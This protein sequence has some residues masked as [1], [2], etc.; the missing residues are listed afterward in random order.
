ME[1][2]KYDLSHNIEVFEIKNVKMKTI[3]VWFMYYMPLDKSASLNALISR[4]I[5]KGSSKYRNTGEIAR[6]LYENYGSEIGVDIGLKGE[7]YTFSMYTRF[8]N[9]K[10]IPIDKSLTSSVLG[11]FNDILFNSLIIDENFQDNY[12]ELEKQ[13][14]INVIENRVN[15][16]DTYALE[17]CIEIMCKNEPYGI[18]R[19]GRKEWA[20]NINSGEVVRRYNEIT[21]S[22]PLKIYV[23]GNLEWCGALGYI[24]SFFKLKGGR[25]IEFINKSVE[26]NEVTYQTDEMDISQSR[27]CMGFRTGINLNSIEYPALIVL[28]NILGG[29]PQSKLF[30]EIREKE[31]LCYSIYSLL[32]KYK[33]LM[34]VSCGIDYDK[35]DV[36]IN[37]IKELIYK[38]KSGEFTDEEFYNALSAAKKDIQM[39][40]DNTFN[41]LSYIQGLNIYK[42]DYSVIDLI[43]K[44][45][46]VTRNDVINC[47]KKIELD[48]IYL[49]GS[50]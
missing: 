7:I 23:M 50:R 16:K 34:F 13:N 21:S 47:C 8:L 46:D 9:N 31:S 1:I 49:L 33:G 24:E 17:R 28:N 30:V 5:L 2:K 10:I 6:F 35:K 48:T 12:L 29:T 4:L 39:V 14:L 3:I 18:D 43:M 45:K 26:V 36:V 27:L 19:L 20:E 44:L 25:E 37:R 11:F 32:E 22:M 42:T 38:I 41:F 15:N 40:M